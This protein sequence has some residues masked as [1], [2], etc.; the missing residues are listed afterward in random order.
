MKKYLGGL[1]KMRKTFRKRIDRKD[2]NYIFKQKLT[3]ANEK[4][5]FVATW[6]A[7]KEWKTNLWLTH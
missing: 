2:K 3:I 4:Y 5:G 7:Y 6:K 1:R